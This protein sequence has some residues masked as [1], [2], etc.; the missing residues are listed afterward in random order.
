MGMYLGL[1]YWGK[2]GMETIVLHFTLCAPDYKRCEYMYVLV[3]TRRYKYDRCYV[4]WS[5][6]INPGTDSR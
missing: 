5:P 2:D 4:D 1:S 3:C 6:A